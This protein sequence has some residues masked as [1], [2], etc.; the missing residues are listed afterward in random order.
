MASFTFLCYEIS[1]SKK[2]PFYCRGQAIK[3]LLLAV[4]PEGGS[5]LV[6]LPAFSE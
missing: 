3:R 5:S 4:A 6:F 2:L 1:E